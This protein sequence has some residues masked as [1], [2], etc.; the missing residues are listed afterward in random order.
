MNDLVQKIDA[1]VKRH[2]TIPLIGVTVLTLGTLY[3]VADLLKPKVH[4]ESAQKRR[5]EVMDS[6]PDLRPKSIPVRSNL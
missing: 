4:R 5:I 2:Q 1:F 6:N 3:V